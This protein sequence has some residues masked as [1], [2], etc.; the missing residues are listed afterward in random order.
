MYT[1]FA[2][3]NESDYPIV[4]FAVDQAVQSAMTVFLNQQ[5]VVFDTDAEEIEFDGRYRPEDGEILVINDFN[6]PDGLAQA[7]DAPLNVPVADPATLSF[8]SIRALFFGKVETDGSASIYLQNFERRRVISD[9]GFSIYHSR[10]VYKK[11]EGSGLMLDTK[12]AAKLSGRQLKF[13]SYFQVRQIFDMG[14]YV[15]EATDQDVRD[16]ANLDQVHVKNVDALLA[17]SDS[18]VRRKL[19]F[20]R[21][22]GILEAV[23]ARRIRA[24]AKDFKIPIKCVRINGSERIKLPDEKKDLKTLLRFLDEDYYKS[25]L[26]KTKFVT[27][28]KRRA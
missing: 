8:E 20:I 28:S 3:T 7:V 17:V 5:V 22:S 24:V 4:R 12:I 14:V 16:F 11:I 25:S 23:S 18:W 15:Q 1:L 19:S 10:G 21:A 27:N 26:S 2:Y 9:A 13:S 6:S